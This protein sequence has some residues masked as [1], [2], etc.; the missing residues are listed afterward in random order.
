M[1]LSG[2]SSLTLPIGIKLPN[3][4]IYKDFLIS[5]QMVK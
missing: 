1:G 3:T 4:L 5:S 2:I